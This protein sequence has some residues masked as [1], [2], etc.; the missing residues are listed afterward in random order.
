MFVPSLVLSEEEA[1]HPHPHRI[2]FIFVVELCWVGLVQK[3]QIPMVG[4]EGF[5]QIGSFIVVREQ[6]IVCVQYVDNPV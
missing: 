3:P 2:K 5:R 6:L 1:D 4:L